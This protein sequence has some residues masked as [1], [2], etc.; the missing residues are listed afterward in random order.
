MMANWLAHR[1]DAIIAVSNYSAERFTH[2]SKLPMDR[3][4]I[5]PNCVDLDRFRPLH[6]DARLVKRYGLQ[7]SK[8]IM[9][10]GRLASE[11]RYKGFDQ[12]IEIMPKLIKRFSN[13]KYLIIGEGS[14]RSRLEA[15]VEALGLSDRV[16]FTGYVSECEMT[17]HYNLSDVY[18]MPSTGEGFGIVLLEAIACGVPVVSSRVAGAREALLD[19]QLGRLIDPGNPLALLDAVASA[20]EGGRPRERMEMINTF[21]VQNFRARVA[22]WCQAQALNLSKSPI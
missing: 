14:D 1:V 18:V 16:I 15:K 20:L 12:V 8:V 17:A 9:T 2:W 7:S 11:E 3:A 6:R 4:F 13:I 19:G 22:A 5:L 21:S 10:V